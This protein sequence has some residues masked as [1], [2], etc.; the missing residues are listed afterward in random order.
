MIIE[1]WSIIA[2]DMNERMSEAER[3]KPQT[4]SYA[5]AHGGVLTKQLKLSTPKIGMNP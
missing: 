5:D 3:V 4:P 2:A 1:R